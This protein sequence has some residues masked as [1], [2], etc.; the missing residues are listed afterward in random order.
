MVKALADEL[1]AGQQQMRRIFRQHSQR[2]L[3]CIPLLGLHSPM[4]QEARMPRILHHIW[5]STMTQILK[6]MLNELSI[7]SKN[8]KFTRTTGKVI[9]KLVYT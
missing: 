1:A 3:D 4:E 6:L 8:F 5:I 9:N 2:I 7:L